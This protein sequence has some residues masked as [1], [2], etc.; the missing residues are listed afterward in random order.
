MNI[1]CISI[2]VPSKDKKGYQI[3]SFHR[4]KYLVFKGHKIELV[5]FCN[6]KENERLASQELV[7]I[8]IKVH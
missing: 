2:N 6:N 5:C 1:L 3:L 4:L 7:K 8:G